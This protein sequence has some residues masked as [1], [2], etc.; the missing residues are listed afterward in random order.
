MNGIPASFHRQLACILLAAG[1]ALAGCAVAPNRGPAQAPATRTPRA[2]QLTPYSSRT[3]TLTRT[4]TNPATPTP[5]PSPSP[6]PRT[7]AVAGGEDMFGIAWRYGITLEDLMAANPDVNPNFL[8]IGT[9]LVIPA[10]NLPVPSS[11]PPTPTPIPLETGRLNC[12]RS[13]DDGIWCFWPVHNPHSFALENISAIFRLAD[14]DAQNIQPRQAFLVLD[15]L[16]PGA[17]LPLAVY[18]PPPLPDPF[19]ASVEIL[20]VLPN[21]ADDGRY[22]PA[23]LETQ[24]VQIAPDGLSA[25]IT[26]EVRL[27]QPDD[28]AQRVWVAAVAY[29]AE[30]KVTGVRRWENTTAGPIASGQSLEVQLE[31]YSVGAPI[32][33]V[34]LFAEAR[35]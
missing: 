9:L 21:P 16:P 8:S 25:S 24:Q 33:R 12:A 31:L 20:T 15:V 17:S 30:G 6:T 11:E 29:D 10:S 27:E 26:A 2:G 5:L 28:S 13:A 3:P 14:R 4:P 32:A 34:E 18:Y 1:L 7:H 23:Q 22:L 35:P 19:Q